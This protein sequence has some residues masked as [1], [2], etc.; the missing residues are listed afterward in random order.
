MPTDHS[1]SDIR[2]MTEEEV[3]ELDRRFK[4]KYRDVMDEEQR[5][6][7][8][9]GGRDLL[10][11]LDDM[12]ARM[13]VATQ[14]LAAKVSGSVS[15]KDFEARDREQFTSQHFNNHPNVLAHVRYNERTD[16]DG[17]RVLFI[18]EIQSDWHQEGRKKGYAGK[19]RSIAEIDADLSR[20]GRE[21]NA[22]IEAAAALPDS[23]MSEF[24]RMNGQIRAMADQMRELNHE[25]D[26][27]HASDKKVP[28]APFKATD[29][30]A[31]LAF[32]RMVRHA[33]ENGFDRIAW[34]T[35]EQQAERYDLSKQI[36]E[37]NYNEDEGGGTLIGNKD[38]V[39]YSI[40]DKT[41]VKRGDLADYVGK[42]MAERLLAQEPNKHGLRTL[43]GVDLKV[44][45]EGMR[46]FYDK[47]LP[48]AVNKWA[49]RLGGK[50]GQTKITVP[51]SK[52]KFEDRK[53]TAEERGVYPMV[54]SIDLTDTMREAAL[55]GQPLFS[56]PDQTDT[57]EFKRWFGDSKVV[58]ESGKPLVVYHGTRADISEFDNSRANGLRQGSEGF[59]FTKYQD[60]ASGYAGTGPT[61]GANVMPVYVRIENPY[62]TDGRDSEHTILSADRLAELEDEGFD[63]WIVADGEEV[64]AFRPEQIK[65]AIGNRGTF[66][67]SNPSILFSRPDTLAGKLDGAL[68]NVKDI[69]LPAG[70]LVGDFLNR[71]PGSLHWWHK[72]VGTQFNL[73]ER[74]PAYKRVFDS[75]QGFLDDVSYYATEAMNEA[76]KLLPQLESWND[77]GKQ[78]ISPEDAKAIG[79]P[80]FD[81]TLKFVRKSDGEVIKAY[82]A[83][84]AGVVWTDNELRSRYN[85]TDEQ[86]GLYREFRAAVDKSL[87]NLVKAQMVNYA[88]DDVLAVRAKAMDAPTVEDAAN[89]LGTH[90]V[91]LGKMFPKRAKLLNKTATDLHAKAAKARELMSKGYAPLSR[92]G[93]HVV[94]VTDKD[95]EQIY[96]GLFDTKADAA[97]MSRKMKAEH[98]DAEVELGMMSQDT[99]KLFQGITP[100]T[101]ELFGEMLGLDSKSDDP[102]DKAFQTYLKLAKNNRSALKRLIHRKGT[103]GYSEDASRVLASFLVS[104]AR[105]GATN[106]HS[107]ETVKAI[108]AIPRS[109]GELKDHALSLFEYTRNPQEEA[110]AL[111]ALNFAQFLGGSIAA[112]MV[113]LTQSVTMTFPYLS[114][115]G[116]VA[117]A[118][119]RMAQAVQ[120]ALKPTTGDAKLD[121][122][123]QRGVEEGLLAPQEIHQLMAQA[124]GAATLRSGDGTKAG[125]ALA[126]ASNLL[127]KVSLAWGKVFSLAESFNRRAAFIAAYR[128]AQEQGIA[129]P[130]RF[131]EKAV[132][133]T[134]GVYSR[135]N[136]PR[137]ARGA[138]GATVFC[139]DE[140]TEAMTQRGWLGPDELRVGD[141]I[142]SFDMT[143]EKLTWQPVQQVFV[144]DHDGDM[145]HATSQSLDML[146]TPDHRVVHYK[147]LR[148]RG[149]PRGTTHWQL[150]IAEAQ[151]IPASGT[152]QIP[153][154][155]VFLHSPIGEPVP[156]ALVP[157]IGWVVTEGNVLK[158]QK[159]REDL[160][161]QVYISQNEGTNAERIRS[162]L[163]VAGLS[164]RENTWKY[165]GG[166]ATH[167]RFALKKSETEGLRAMLPGKHLTPALVMRMT[168]AQ[169]A[170]L[171]DRMLAGDGSVNAD[172]SR[173]FIQNQ[174]ATLDSFTMALTLLGI[175][176]SVRSHGP[177]CRAVLLREPKKNTAGRFSVKKTERVHYRGRVWCPIVPSTCTWVARR[178]GM[179]FIT[180]NTFKQFS[181][182]YIEMLHRMATQGGP[183]GKKAALLAL[184]VL[185]MMAGSSGIPGSDDLDDVIDGLLQRLGY[186]FSSKQAKHE[187]FAGILGEGG[188]NFVQRGISGLPG[189][190]LDVSGRL[191]LGNLIPGTGLLKK[192]DDHTRDILEVVGPTGDLL[193]RAGQSANALASGRF[194][195]A[196]ATIMPVAVRNALQ[197]M[198]MASTGMYRDARGRKVLDT[199]G[200][201]AAF[202]A[203]GFQPS[204][205]AEVQKAT[206]EV[207][208]MIALNKMVEREIADQWAQGI[209]EKDQDKIADARQQLVDWN[210]KNPTSR[211]RVD[212]AQI[213]RRLREMRLSKVQRLAKTAPAEI[214][215]VVSE[216][217]QTE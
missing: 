13:G 132:R 148:T 46:A 150:G 161:G 202:K 34:T 14:D 66:D 44:G 47:I 85:L 200:I 129:N 139:V 133:E 215:R 76:P 45:G 121:A 157:I 78:P 169:L 110:H 101:L 160:G 142:A 171:V 25:W 163:S 65:S 180:H 106:L 211:I 214:R 88:G 39:S 189:V 175:S 59:Y 1:I 176:Y 8:R 131:A 165:K 212:S 48:S 94:Y 149:A 102:M 213:R 186:N 191:G 69:R 54:H 93:Q 112:A 104:N 123:I 151:D 184:G 83:E 98:P 154:S 49:K 19:T 67:P 190:P 70:K 109:Q 37:L 33:A 36:D 15:I 145:V 204:S 108:Q 173:S 170:V 194:G 135:A 89:I 103:A 5:D 11:M 159:G 120:D 62:R 174:G 128:T 125:N 51:E 77:L 201:E 185:F 124:R 181:I 16:A 156:D 91:K 199:N 188:A 137:W 114:Q 118:G 162:D 207:Q 117:K 92:F 95:G 206:S 74:Y 23:Q 64:I 61:K 43:R 38:D 10:E 130:G 166:N 126:G 172:G 158:R 20:I 31:M 205:V 4:K 75:V 42:E 217:L 152:V 208:Q 57:P 164:W 72:T 209:F 105:L 196:G 192:K 100:E 27:A 187:F 122:A 40:L 119:S 96:F 141:L 146:M 84:G 147:K 26:A 113:N 52:I 115:W 179:P 177:N 63:G 32:K 195:E 144:K 140:S 9:K 210:R 79:A 138:V 167:V 22:L 73:A 80:I 18:E 81:G 153:T 155:A 24:N 136:R 111:R 30:W 17:K 60:D 53:K 183:E 216:R 182:A 193:S 41:D 87:T 198:D 127:A 178:N 28:D 168:T 90:L 107:G 2:G 143:Q 55:E 99:F 12:E 68:N 29:E 116:G 21:R 203:I 3:A 82:D 71:A 6:L 50:V 56:R 7:A 58:D 197:G 134:Q 97:A 35:G 86:I